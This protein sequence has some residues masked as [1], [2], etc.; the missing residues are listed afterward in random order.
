MKASEK[1]FSQE[2]LRKENALKIAERI[3]EAGRIQDLN[4]WAE[5]EREMQQELL[6]W[7]EEYHQEMLEA[8][9]NHWY[10]K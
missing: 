1:V 3:V 6:E 4:D 2:L 8:V 5:M 10:N 7:K 9:K